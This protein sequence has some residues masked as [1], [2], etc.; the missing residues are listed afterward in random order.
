MSYL[1]AAQQ[2][3]KRPLKQAVISTSAL[4]QSR[5]ERFYSC[6]R[7]RIG[8]HTCPGG[9]RDS[10]H[11]ADVDYVT[12]LPSLFRLNVGRFYLQLASEPRPATRLS[13][14]PKAFEA[15]RSRVCGS[16]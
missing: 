14:N 4:S 10:T 9:D 11:S 12:L 16:D 2:Y 13:R 3:T 5:T 6:E 15:G 8:V 7:Q 1:V